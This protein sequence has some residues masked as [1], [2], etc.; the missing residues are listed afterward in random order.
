[1]A[2]Q[3]DRPLRDLLAKS[4]RVLIGQGRGSHEIW[5]SP[6]T[7]RSFPVFAKPAYPR[8]SEVERAEARLHGP[9]LRHHPPPFK[10]SAKI[11]FGSL[12]PRNACRP[13]DSRRSSAPVMPATNSA[14][15][16]TGR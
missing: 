12:I 11:S 4:G 15:T 3:F 2:P 10:S 13:S 8:L 16:R 9:S 7:E 6:I 14:E 5:R 1:M